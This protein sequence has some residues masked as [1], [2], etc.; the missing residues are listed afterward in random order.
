MKL[1]ILIMAT[2]VGAFAAAATPAMA[3]PTTFLAGASSGSVLD[4]NIVGGK[5]E[6]HKF[7]TGAGTIECTE[8]M[9]SGKFE[10]A[11]ATSSKEI[12]KYSK[13]KAF[14]LIGFVLSPAHYE[15]KPNGE[16]TLEN[17]MIIEPEGGGCQVKVP[18]QGPLNGTSYGN[19][20]MN[21]FMLLEVKAKVGNIISEGNGG[22]C[23]S[24]KETNG[25]YEGVSLVD[26]YA[27]GLPLKQVDL[28]VS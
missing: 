18:A 6:I 28:L 3:W 4:T 17:E 23:G 27:L 13:C 16:A 21:G 8:V 2:V 9:S 15:F 1:K 25:K 19:V 14:K 10:A 11:K 26:A 12:V 7:V 5:T 20:I 22:V 24:S